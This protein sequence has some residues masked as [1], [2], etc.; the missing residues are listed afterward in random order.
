MRVV[1]RIALICFGIVAWC[2]LT[3]PVVWAAGIVGTGSP[4]S[5][6]NEDLVTAL[7]GGG[8]VTFNCGTEP[9]TINAGRHIIAEDTTIRGGNAIILTGQDA[10]QLFLVG[11]GAT[12][13]LEE[14][15]ISDGKSS[16][17]GCVSVD[18]QGTLI[19]NRVEFK[20]CQDTSATLGGGAV[21][22]LGIYTA[23]ETLFESN[24]A[25]SGG[26][27]VYNRGRL[28]SGYAIF[29]ANK[30]GSDSGAVANDSDGIVTIA[31]AKFIGNSAQGSGGAIGNFL[32]TPTTTGSF[33][34]QRSLF[35]DNSSKSFGGALYNNSGIVSV[36]NS[37]F[38]RNTS[39]VGG[40]VSD[41]GA[42]ITIRFSTFTDNRADNG[43]AISRSLTGDVTLG[44]S[45]V[46]GSRNEANTE[47][48][49]ECDGPEV[50]TLGLNIVDDESCITPASGTD[51]RN[52]FPSLE[53]LADNGGFSMTQMPNAD[54]PALDKVPLDQCPA[55]DQRQAQ[56]SGTCDIG[57]TERGGLFQ[58]AFMPVIGK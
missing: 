28:L 34:V 3:A 9:H 7:A 56:R 11:N 46:A 55:V 43:G 42:Q 37:T 32:S 16:V 5:C 50:T 41:G 57:A 30:A 18:I 27:A 38:V 22:N 49:S 33:T 51:M 25:Q 13:I 19:T 2:F 29:E 40:G 47:D 15:T 4:S 21:F 36:E 12:L 8:E 1:R 26:G 48:E 45:I 44:Y 14:I 53:E 10:R 20:S 17:G 31:D 35:I 39:N 58:S 54:S 24:E 23:T 52:T 6:E